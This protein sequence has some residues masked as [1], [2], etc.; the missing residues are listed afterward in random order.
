MSLVLKEFFIKVIISIFK[1][2]RE[3][4]TRPLGLK[5]YFIKLF[6]NTGIYFIYLY[7]D[8]YL[9]CGEVVT[10]FEILQKKCSG[11][12]KIELKL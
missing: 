12:F 6:T 11:I 8:I 2:S 1:E 7:L 5:Y 10:V 4:K 9:I 3:K